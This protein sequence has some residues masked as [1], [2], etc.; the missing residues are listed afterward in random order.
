M[1]WEPVLDDELAGRARQVVRE[2]CD[3]LADRHEDA[4][5]DLALLWAY[6]A[7]AFDDPETS[8]QYER[9]AD[10]L[11]ARLEAGFDT[12]ALSDGLAG[13]GWVLV[14]LGCELPDVLA[15]IDDALLDVLATWQGRYE[16]SR[17]AIGIGVYFLERLRADPDLVAA[18]EG[19]QRVVQRLVATA[20]ITGDRATW[21]TDPSLLGPAKQARLPDGYRDCGVAHGV[22]GAI[23]FLARAAKVAP[24]SSLCEQGLGWLYGQRLPIG[25]GSRFPSGVLRDGQP[26]DRARTAWCYGDLGVATICWD[27]AR[28]L[29]RPAEPWLELV[30]ELAAREPAACGII[31]A[32]L[33]HG[34]I[35]MAHGLGRCFAASR[36][37]TLRLAARRWI[38]LALAH[39]G[40]NGIAGFVAMQPSL[41]G[42]FGP[43]ADPGFLEG[44]AGIALALLAASGHEEPAWDRRLMWDM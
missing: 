8:T 29:A 35:G 39:R 34:A 5:V 27:A 16:L 20:E 14:H 24:T 10:A 37:V 32:G 33:C 22:A 38:E 26:L 12:P 13:A 11:I 1:T 18:R 25:S 17:G 44:A 42:V 31:D 3:A 21:H 41:D 9:A 6:A 4:P 40:P 36:E 2:I 43:N 28:R 23:A 7:A 30:F 15:V 19:I